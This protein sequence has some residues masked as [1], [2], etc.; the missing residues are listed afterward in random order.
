M[1]YLVEN[2]D[3]DIVYSNPIPSFSMRDLHYIFA[4]LTDKKTRHTFD[5]HEYYDGNL[6]KCLMK[7]GKRL[8][9]KWETRKK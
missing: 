9:R 3:Y 2:N 6:E 4:Y 1:K 8:I 7:L 5:D